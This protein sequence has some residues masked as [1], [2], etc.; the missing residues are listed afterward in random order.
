MKSYFLIFAISVGSF[1]YGQQPTP[2]TPQATPGLDSTTVRLS[3]TLTIGDQLIVRA[4]NVEEISDRPYRIDSEGF[5]T[6]PLAGKVQV[7]NKTLEQV[8]A[9]LIKRLSEYVKNPLVSVTVVQYHSEPVFL[10]GAF[11][12]P[13]IYPL[14]GRR[15]LI[16]MLTAV[17]GIQPNASHRIKVTRRLEAGKI[18]LSTA[19]DDTEH[20]TS[21]VEIPISSLQQNISPEE[22]ITL[23]PFD[24]ISVE[25]AEVVYMTGEIARPGSLEIGE[26]D[27]IS[28]AQAISLSG[29]LTR[30]ASKRIRILRPVLNSSKRAEIPI[31]FDKIT[32]G[33]AND[34]PLM[35][36]DILFVPRDIGRTTIARVATTIVLPLALSAV[37][38]VLIT[39][40]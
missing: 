13:G 9:D 27:Y 29:G 30:E 39:T 1:V 6:L 40:R 34:F 14:Q 7:A 12:S 32:T 37:T 4:Q 15:T 26:R 33:D 10:V 8:E 3:Y 5:V 11:K 38:A 18:P 31:D 25:H 2:N 22:D 36:N 16:E 17:G 23:A 35:P 19:F 28:V 21:V 24:V 20:R